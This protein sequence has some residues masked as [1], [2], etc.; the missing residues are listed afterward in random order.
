MQSTLLI[1]GNG[2]LGQEVSRQAQALGIPTVTLSRTSSNADLACDLTDP[3]HLQALSQDIQPTHI[4]ASASSGR[5][6]SEAYRSIFL[7]GTRN[8]LHYFP[9]S[10]LTFISST[11]VYRQTDGSLVTEADSTPPSLL[12][13]TTFPPTEKSAIL[14]EAEQLTLDTNGTALRL[15]G[16]YGPHRSVILKKLLSAE[17]SLE[18]TPE[19]LGIRLINQIHVADAAKAILHLINT[20]TSGL[21][22]ITDNTPITQIDLLTQLSQT[23][24]LPLPN[25]APPKPTKRGWTHKAVS[26]QK[27]RAT[28][29]APQYP[30]FLSAIPEILPTIEK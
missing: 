22:N 26:N 25:S 24:N 15:S 7:Q 10:H 3:A 2:Y 8:L 21:F 23:L 17:S 6:G 20:E 1:A 27:L 29:W 16:I 19:G 14:L 28:N 18:E 11:S 30:S 12:S 13:S 9:N 4:L 5:G